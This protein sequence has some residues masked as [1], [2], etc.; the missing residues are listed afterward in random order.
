MFSQGN[1]T[2]S[3]F[4]FHN[5]YGAYMLFDFFQDKVCDA[6]AAVELA[7]NIID[8]LR[9]YSHLHSDCCLFNSLLAGEV[10]FS[11]WLDRC[12]MVEK[13]RVSF[14]AF[15]RSQSFL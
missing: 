4:I 12:S 6:V 11:V 1:L 10:H 15:E 2:Q 7:Y 5:E 9:R 8:A 14:D 13:L 3:T